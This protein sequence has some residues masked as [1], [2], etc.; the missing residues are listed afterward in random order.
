MLLMTEIQNTNKIGRTKWRNNKS[1]IRVG[2]FN[3][4]LIKLIEVDKLNKN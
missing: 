3:T 2:D 1:T 4:C